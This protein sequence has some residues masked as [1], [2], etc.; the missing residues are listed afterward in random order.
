MN[1]LPYF[2][3][4]SDTK[5][6]QQPNTTQAATTVCPQNPSPHVFS[7]QM[8]QEDFL[9]SLL[10]TAG[11][12]LPSSTAPPVVVKTSPPGSPKPLAVVE[13]EEEQ[14]EKQEPMEDGNRTVEKEEESKDTDLKFYMSSSSSAS[15]VSIATLVEE[16]QQDTVRINEETFNFL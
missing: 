13:E 7:P 8:P 9:N 12:L 2:P 16:P 5:D 14:P 1:P 11:L 3:E 10:A 6:V 15:S 4:P